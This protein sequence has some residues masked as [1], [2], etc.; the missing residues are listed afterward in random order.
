MAADVYLAELTVYDPGLP[1][2][3]T[4]YYSTGQGFTTTPSQTPANTVFDP[5]IRNPVDISRNLFSAGKTTGK[6]TVG[7]GDL[8]LENGDGALDALLTYGL[9]GQPYIV[10]CGP[11]TASY[12]SGFTTVA[13]GT[14]QQAEAPD[15]KT[16]R[17]K[18]RDNQADFDQPIQPTKYAGT[19]TLPAGLEGVEDLLGKPK[20]LCFGSV[21]NV[22]AVLVNSARLIYQVNDGAIQS[23]D[24]VYDN[25]VPLGP[26][27]AAFSSVGSGFGTNTPRAI[28]TGYTDFIG[29]ILTT[30]AVGDGGKVYYSIDE[31]FWLNDASAGFGAT[32]LFAVAMGVAQL[33]GTYQYIV[34]GA[35]GALSTFS[36]PGSPTSRTS[37]F[38]ASTIRALCYAPYNNL[39]IAVGDSGKIST[40]A[41][42][43]ATW[44]ARTSG[45]ATALYGVIAGVNTIVA[46]GASGVILTSTDGTTWTARTSGFSTSDIRAIAYGNGAF[47]CCGADDKIGM[48]VG[49]NGATWTVTTGTI[50]SSRI[51]YGAAYD[52]GTFLV[53]GEEESVA[54]FDGDIWILRTQVGASSTDYVAAAPGINTPRFML[55]AFTGGSTDLFQANGVGT[56][57]NTTQLQD[58]TLAPV[59]GAYKTYLAGGYFRLG[60]PPAGQITADVTQGTTAADRTPAQIWKGILTKAG[61]SAGTASGNYLS[62][63]ITALDALVDGVTGDWIGDEDTFAA[64]LDRAAATAG[65]WWGVDRLGR[66]RIAQFLAPTG[67][68]T[69]AI[70]PNDLLGPLQRVTLSDESKGLPTYRSIVR[71][72]RNYAVQTSGLAGAV[73]DDRRARLAKE[74]LEAI[75]EDAAVQT[76][77]RLAV[78][79]IE[80]TGF[81]NAADAQDEATRRQALRGVL[82]NAY[83]LTVP[84]D[85]V[86]QLIDLDAVGTLTHPRYGFSG[87]VLVRVIG[88]N[89]DARNRRVTLRVWK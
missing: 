3:R 80:E 21:L 17:I 68:S 76:A 79:T 35:S 63:D 74:W 88:V 10:R 45:V 59:A 70:G 20:P 55:A 53:A 51:L 32:N 33:T 31:S 47:V 62:A 5:R 41:D 13:T 83:D 15:N 50:G 12:P 37:Q 89:P 28:A 56:Y 30:I 73:T 52:Q 11:P 19:N 40:S 87:G 84:L 75:D 72:A 29:G 46:V 49:E 44:T 67:S 60:S 27:L 61:K 4:L 36:A 22:P 82:R 2:T 9:D 77:H 14:M 16:L 54:I 48:S 8:I 24:A 18:I 42:F 43:G 39:W 23:F 1:G 85:S 65:A 38:G 26:G 71:Y 57:S 25:G 64:A 81:L 58:D 7:Y 66:Y 69:F 78:Q 6:S 34:A 86:T